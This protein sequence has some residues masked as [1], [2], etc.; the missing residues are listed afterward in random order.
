MTDWLEMLKLGAADSTEQRVGAA[1]VERLRGLEKAVVKYAKLK[2]AAEPTPE[3]WAE[4]EA[5]WQKV[6]QQVEGLAAEAGRE[7]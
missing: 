3:Q 2:A 7:E 6:A 1:E 4:Y 5:K